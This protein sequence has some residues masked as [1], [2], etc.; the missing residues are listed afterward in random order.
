[1]ASSGRINSPSVTVPLLIEYF[2]SHKFGSRKQALHL[3]SSMPHG[4][5]LSVWKQWF[6]CNKPP[7]PQVGPAE[8]KGHDFCILESSSSCTVQGVSDLFRAHA[9][10]PFELVQCN[11]KCSIFGIHL[12]TVLIF[13]IALP[14]TQVQPCTAIHVNDRLYALPGLPGWGEYAGNQAFCAAY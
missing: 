4:R 3:V 5:T 13:M 6:L 14:Y 2:V 7:S 10:R 11:R 1:M 12:Y 9:Y 8:S